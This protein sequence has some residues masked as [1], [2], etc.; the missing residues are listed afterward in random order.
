VGLNKIRKRGKFLNFKVAIYYTVET[1]SVWYWYSTH[2]KYKQQLKCTGMKGNL[3]WYK[4]KK[5]SL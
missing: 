1:D 4:C 3:I 5:R 2:H